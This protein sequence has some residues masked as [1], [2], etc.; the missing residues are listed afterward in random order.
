[1]STKAAF[2]K[3]REFRIEKINDNASSLLASIREANGY[4]DRINN[5]YLCSMISQCICKNATLNSLVSNY[6]DVNEYCNK[7]V[8]GELYGDEVQLQALSIICRLVIC[9]VSASKSIDGSIRIG[10][11]IYG[12]SI[13]SFEEC[14]YI[15][16]DE[17]HEHYDPLY[18]IN[19]EN[20]QKTK[21]FQRNDKTIVKL[22]NIFL[23]EEFNYDIDMESNCNNKNLIQPTIE[24]GDINKFLIVEEILTEN[25]SVILNN[26]N[27]V[28]RMRL[29]IKPALYFRGRKATDFKPK[30]STKRNGKPSEPMAPRYFPDTENHH[31][32]NLLI[33]NAYLLGD[34]LGICLEICIVT[35]EINGYT[36]YHPYFKFQVHPTD[37]NSPNINPRFIFLGNTVE[38]KP[39][40]ELL[41]QLP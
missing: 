17:E 7:I 21:V 30:K 33:P 18:V 6:G 27:P 5:Q 26:E 19:M 38:L 29:E 39:Y 3:T 34:L 12:E 2:T 22:L 25:T 40:S 16:Y 23:K 9:I 24:L 36:Y 8:K 13:E 4:P 20:Q 28:E 32:L 14:I 41:K 1:M 31:Y 37:L 11:N 35:A 15:L 10:N